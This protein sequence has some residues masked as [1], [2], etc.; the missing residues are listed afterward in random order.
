MSRYSQAKEIRQMI[1]EKQASADQTEAMQKKRAEV[2]SQ[3]GSCLTCIHTK[4]QCGIFLICSFKNKKVREYNYCEHYSSPE[5]KEK[6][7]KND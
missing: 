3:N 1:S 4:S 2:V 6:E 7:T 5:S